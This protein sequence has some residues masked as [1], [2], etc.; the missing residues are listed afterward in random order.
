MFLSEAS[1]TLASSRTWSSFQGTELGGLLTGCGYMTPMCA[2]SFDA[3]IASREGRRGWVS[4]WSRTTVKLNRVA[5]HCGSCWECGRTSASRLLCGRCR[6]TP[7]EE[8]WGVALPTR[9]IHVVANLRLLCGRWLG[10]FGGRG[11]TKS[12]VRHVSLFGP[13]FF[14]SGFDP[15]CSQRYGCEQPACC[16]T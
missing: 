3:F 13:P 7:Y 9:G 6:H 5:R 14:V 1:W 12:V 4:P 2:V 16:R 8:G 10:Q 11:R 15:A